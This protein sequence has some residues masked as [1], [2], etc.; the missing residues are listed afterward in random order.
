MS[1]RRGRKR[2]RRRKLPGWIY[3]L[4][5]DVPWARDHYKIG[6]T[7]YSVESALARAVTGSSYKVT[8]YARYRVRN[9][10]KA[11]KKLHEHFAY[12]RIEGGG[13][14]WFRLNAVDRAK[15]Q[16]LLVGE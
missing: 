11:E 14:E 10:H 13:R 8:E 1:Q 9:V 6:K 16:F 3:V 2:R 15:I 7:T 5:K 12:K 4:H